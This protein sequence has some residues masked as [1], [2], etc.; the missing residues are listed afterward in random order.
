[1]SVGGDSAWEE[2]LDKASG[3]QPPRNAPQSA[4][5]AALWAG[6]IT[7]VYGAGTGFQPRC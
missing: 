2:F 5:R 1:M 3:F 7:R 4:L 6:V